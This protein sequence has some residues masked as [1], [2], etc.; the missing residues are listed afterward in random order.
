[1]RAAATRPPVLRPPCTTRSTR[2]AATAPSSSPALADALSTW[3]V[4]RGALPATNASVRVVSSPDGTGLS[5]RAV[6]PIPRGGAALAVPEAAFIGASA[7]DASPVGAATAG[8][9]PWLRIAL[10]LL[11]ARTTPSDPLAPYAAALPASPDAPTFWDDDDLALLAGTSVGDGVAAYRAYFAERHAELEA[12]L[13]SKQRDVFPADVFTPAAFAWAAA[14]VRARVHAP[15]DGAD[16]AIVPGVDLTVHARGGGALRLGREGLLN[17]SRAARVEPTSDVAPGEAI[18]LD[19]GA[20]GRT[21]AQILLDYGA[22][23]TAAGD[24]GAGFALTLTLP[25]DDPFL[26]DK[27]DIAESA[28]YAAS[29]TFVLTPDA[30]PPPDLLAY[31]RLMNLGGGDAFLLEPVLRA[32]AWRHVCDPVSPD[33]ESAVCASM[34]DGCAVTAAR[35]AGDAAGDANLLESN[36]LSRRAAMALRVRSGERAALAAA[37][38]WFGGRREALPGLEYYQERRLRGLGL[39]DDDGTHSKTYDSYFKDGIA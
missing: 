33:N 11:H 26:D 7:V 18:T 1:M 34:A 20:G 13:F 36:T 3:L 32:D 28:G 37:A 4:A 25:P 21:D 6:R 12:T 39:L 16:A 27:L 30:P 14:T 24:D 23:D 8:L 29:A 19:K 2:T 22:L 38:R 31:L 35:V 9:E 5:L 17:A 10:A 15:L